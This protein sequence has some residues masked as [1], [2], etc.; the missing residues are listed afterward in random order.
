M[1]RQ[2]MEALARSITVFVTM[3]KYSELS[4]NPICREK[5][6]PANCDYSLCFFVMMKYMMGVSY[7]R[8]HRRMYALVRSTVLR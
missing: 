6:N 8:T 2:A 7:N 4:R 1:L 5:W 3:Q